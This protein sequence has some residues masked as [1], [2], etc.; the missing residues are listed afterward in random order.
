MRDFYDGVMDAVSRFLRHYLE[1]TLPKKGYSQTVNSKL[2]NAC[3]RL[4]S[5][6]NVKFEYNYKYPHIVNVLDDLNSYAIIYQ[7]GQQKILNLVAA[8]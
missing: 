5:A 6:L 1:E 2:I 7:L 4:N 8:A 3:L